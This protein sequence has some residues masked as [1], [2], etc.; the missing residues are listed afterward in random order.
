MAMLS[1]SRRLMAQD[2][3]RSPRSLWTAV[4]VKCSANPSLLGIGGCRLEPKAERFL[5]DE[6]IANVNKPNSRVEGTGGFDKEK[7]HG[8][9]DR[10][11][12][13]IPSPRLDRSRLVLWA[14]GLDC[15]GMTNRLLRS[16][17]RWASW[18][19]SCFFLSGCETLITSST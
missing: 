9:Q 3:S 19:V 6:N 1:T 13:T 17:M 4:L 8:L 10:V 5:P 11:R 7:K 15:D 12:R 14:S 2:L 18:L 16:H